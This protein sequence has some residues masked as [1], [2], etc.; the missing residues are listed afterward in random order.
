MLL[1]GRGVQAQSSASELIL[2]AIEDFTQHRLAEP[3]LQVS[4]TRYRRLFETARD[5]MAAPIAS[6][7][8]SSAFGRSHTVKSTTSA[9]R[10]REAGGR[11][12]GLGGKPRPFV[13]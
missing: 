9:M 8:P 13:P 11:P 1:N 12:G 10:M 3:E 5:G 4:E 7:R 6:T 2:L